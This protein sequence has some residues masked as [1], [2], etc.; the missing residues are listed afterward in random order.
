VVVH[1]I[2]STVAFGVVVILNAQGLSCLTGVNSG[3][4]GFL[5]TLAPSLAVLFL[6]F[7]QGVFLDARLPKGRLK[8]TGNEDLEA[9]AAPLLDAAHRR[10]AP[11]I[12]HEENVLKRKEQ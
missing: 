12:F 9:A 6:T 2:L 1:A 10:L 3:Q 8:P 4:L 11:D 7:F 5:T